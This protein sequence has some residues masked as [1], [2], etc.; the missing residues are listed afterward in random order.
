LRCKSGNKKWEPLA[1]IFVCVRGSVLF[2]AG[3]FGSNDVTL[4]IVFDQWRRINLR[5][6]ALR[7]VVA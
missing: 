7:A 4:E 5:D 2:L 6:M 1:P 3:R